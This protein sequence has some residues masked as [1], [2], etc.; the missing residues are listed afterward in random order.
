MFGAIAGAVFLNV[1]PPDLAFRFAF[2]LGLLLAVG[3][4]FL[5]IYVPESPRWLMTHGREEQAEQTVRDIEED[6]RG[7]AEVEELREPNDSEAINLRERRA[8]GFIELGRTLFKLY[9]A[10]AGRCSGAM[11]SE[12]C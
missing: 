8:I 11:W 4:V 7:Y 10:R 6:V 1:L 12:R 2:G 3:I 5:R 9:P